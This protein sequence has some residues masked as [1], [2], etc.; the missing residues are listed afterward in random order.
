VDQIASTLLF[1]NIPV[2]APPPPPPTLPHCTAK[3]EPEGE[4]RTEHREITYNFV[5]LVVLLKAL[6]ELARVGRINMLAGDYLSIHLRTQ[7]QDVGEG[8]LLADKRARG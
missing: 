3:E 6:V 5:D 8:D 4:Q 1:V 2:V 7:H